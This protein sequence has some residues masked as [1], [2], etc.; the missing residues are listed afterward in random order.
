MGKLGK[1]LE[2]ILK[3]LAKDLEKILKKLRK[4]LEKIGKQLAKNLEKLAK[5]DSAK[6]PI[7]NK[8]PGSET[9]EIARKNFRV[10]VK[11]RV[12]ENF[13]S[14]YTFN[15]SQLFPTI[16]YYSLQFPTNQPTNFQKIRKNC[17]QVKKIRKSLLYVGILWGNVFLLV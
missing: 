14:S 10:I 15:I 5:F 6:F 11:F 8:I 13:D 3:K 16:P 7:H 4:N 17:Q 12:S 1:N 9:L 2:K